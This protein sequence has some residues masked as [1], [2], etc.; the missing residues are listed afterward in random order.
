MYSLELGNHHWIGTNDV[1]IKRSAIDLVADWNNEP[2][3]LP[4]FAFC[5]AEDTDLFIR[6]AKRG[7]EFAVAE[8]SIIRRGFDPSRITFKGV[9]RLALRYGTTTARLHQVHQAEFNL[10]QRRRKTRRKPIRRIA[11]LPRRVSSRR[12][13]L[14]ELYEVVNLVGW[15]RGFGGW[16]SMIYHRGAR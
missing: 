12:A 4:S 9:M 14:K 3:F 1:L 7:A 5:R 8:S 10:R 15:L 13:F 2:V 6:A 11:R 16:R